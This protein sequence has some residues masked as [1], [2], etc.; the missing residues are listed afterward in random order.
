[1]DLFKDMDHVSKY[2]GR[3]IEVELD[4][5][6][7]RSEPISGN[8]V[9]VDP[10]TEGI[11][12]ARFKHI[13]DAEPTWFDVIPRTAI[14]NISLKHNFDDTCREYFADFGMS[15]TSEQSSPPD[16]ERQEI[17][18]K[19]GEMYA[20]YFR[21]HHIEVEELG[22]GVY[23]VCG[24]VKLLPP[25]K[26]DCFHCDMPLILNRILRMVERIPIQDDIQP[27]Y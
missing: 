1:M 3:P 16:V 17:I 15:S 14:V 9:T 13:S 19:R 11:I 27:L 26:K 5:G 8:L 22:D 18:R 4:T 7:R 21:S 12:I 20:D 6:K 2:L 25:Y 24:N 23:V 10:V